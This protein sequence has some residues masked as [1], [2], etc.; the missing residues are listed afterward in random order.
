MKNVLHFLVLS[1][2]FVA[3]SHMSKVY[4]DSGTESVLVSK[5]ESLVAITAYS[6]L[7]K[8]LKNPLGTFVH[9]STNGPQEAGEIARQ[10]CDEFAKKLPGLFMCIVTSVKVN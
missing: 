5:G 6:A 9:K 2:I 10:R 3:M 1:L 8:E 4:A 7:D